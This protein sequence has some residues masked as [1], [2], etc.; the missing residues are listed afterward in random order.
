MKKYK[1][2]ALAMLACI[3]L[4]G[5]AQ[6]NGVVGKVLDKR[7]NPVMGALVTIESDPLIQTA[8]DADGR[9][10]IMAVKDNV[11][12]IQTGDDAM[13]TVAVGSNKMMTIVMDFSAEK[14]NY[15]FGL[16]QTQAQSTGAV[17][18]V[19]ADQID[20]RSALNIGNSLY[21]NVLGLTTMQKTG[22]VWEQI[23]SMYIRGQK[24]LN[25]NNGIL[26]V[27]DGLERDNNW[28]ALNYI[29]PE[30]V[31]SVSVLRDAAAIALYGYKG[32]NGV[33]NIVTKRG[34]YKSREINFSYD[35][36][37]NFQTR[38][39][40][41][42]DAF[43]YA[44][45]LNEGLANDGKA[46]RYSQNELN[47]FQSGKYPYLYP[48]VNWFDEVFR[49]RGAS[50]IA[51]LTFRGGST[52][53]RYF[54]MM[55]L[56]NNSGFIDR[57]NE[58]EGYSTQDK[59]SKANFRTNLDI[60][61]SPKTRMQANIMGVLNEFSR[62]S[63]GGDNLMGKLY[64]VPSAAFPVQTEDG[65]WGGN[66]TWGANMNPAALSRGRG[67][68]KGH[69]RALYA[70]M[71]LRQDLSSITKGLGASV[72]IGYDNIAS[73][74]ENYTVSYKYGMKSATSW[75]DGE[76]YEFKDF[77]GGEVGKVS[78][79]NAKLDWQHRSFN[80]Q[81]NVDWQ[82]QFG[83]HDIYS[84]LLYTYKYDNKNGTNTTFFH[85]SAGWYTHYGFKNRYMADFT[86]M[87]SASNVLDPGHRWTISPTIGLAWVVSNEGFM[88]NQQVIDFMKLRASFGL[89]NT[90]N[91]PSNG[92]WNTTVGGSS[93]YPIK[94][95]FTGDGG[96]AEG[97]LA[98][99]N[100]TTEKAYKYNGGLDVSLLKGLTLTVD[101]FYERRSD[102]W[103]S[104][105]GR[106]SSVLGISSPYVNG[107]IVDSWGT[108]IGLDYTKTIGKNLKIMAGGTFTYNRNEI[109]E[110]ME[111][112]KAYDYLRSTGKSVGQIFGLQA[113]GYFVD[114]ADIANSIPQQ[115]GP[116]KPG[117]IKYK[118]V[119]GDNV[120]NEN[121]YVA[122]GY[123][124]TCPEI[125]YSFNLGVEWKGIGLNAQFQGVGNYTAYLTSNLY[126][127]LI[128]NTTI[129]QYAYNNR[130]TPATPNARFPRLTTEE[131][132]NNLKTSSVW[133][134]DRSFLKLR[135]CEVYYKLPSTFLSKI[136]MKHAKV[137][138][139]G[140]D[141]LCFDSIDLTDPEA[142]G[143]V[144]PATRSVHVGLSVGF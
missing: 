21:G 32:I 63:L 95:N 49:D 103:V 98:S 101:G 45:A 135:N 34:K 78:G 28:N 57:V 2:I 33:V 99:I 20:T 59:Y 19:Y 138:V 27:I 89:L 87:A 104:A 111:E 127:P 62:P 91:I 13:K 140:V 120:I 86:L 81:A 133:L 128:D 132:D 24:T 54:T 137:Y 143:S 67:Y 51:T 139:R 38:I 44:S 56:Q 70:D 114:D 129:S 75:R 92:Y 117:D 105:A 141:L 14:V 23:P 90:D 76:P 50:D 112:P 4:N 136:H 106:N 113:I 47:A 55:N 65:L 126:R 82:R 7:G 9:F 107:G 35:H 52:K 39:P 5:W 72:R 10:E 41:M 40:D 18:T 37:F 48:N 134:A 119:N 79:D 43:T 42:A 66:E 77:T 80:F 8:T 123:N 1:K 29:T 69:T 142:M 15:G 84:M 144:S 12:R 74:W 16:N 115:F 26:L 125:Y 60:D 53:M 30:E 97:R 122:M 22:N 109:V 36:A 96:W 46:A 11:L 116:V 83:V 124:S 118:D 88:K 130:W 131:M 64:S 85:Q 73:Y 102:I 100:G 121:D 31:E 58:N 3:S 94:D 68:S 25:G 6:D 108:E 93:N 61:L 71:S 110:M 17:S